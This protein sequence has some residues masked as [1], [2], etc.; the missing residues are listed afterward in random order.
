VDTSL[1]APVSVGEDAY[2]G[3]GAVIREDVP[4]GALG[5]SQGEQRNIEG[6][7]KRRAEE[8]EERKR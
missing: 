7:A 5:I 2:T 3:A 1:V 8:A 6:Y 4:P